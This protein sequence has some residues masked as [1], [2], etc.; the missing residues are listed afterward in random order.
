MIVTKLKTTVRINSALVIMAL[1]TIA[2]STSAQSFLESEKWKQFFE[3]KVFAKKAEEMNDETFWEIDQSYTYYTNYPLLFIYSDGSTE[4]VQWQYDGLP[5]LLDKKKSLMNKDFNRIEKANIAYI[6]F[7][8]FLLRNLEVGN[9]IS[10][11]FAI[12]EIE[13]PISL[14]REYYSSPITEDNVVSGYRFYKYGEEVQGFYLGRF[15]KKASRLV[16]DYPEL[17]KKIKNVYIGY[18][19]SDENVRRIVN[20][21]NDWVKENDPFVYEHW[22]GLRIDN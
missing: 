4:E 22:K 10:G 2:Q 17:A 12:V 21:Y 6:V 5:I 3:E 11:D 16:A 19:K 13:G 8:E 14:Y 7:D 1:M 20:E 9:M 18:T 15:D